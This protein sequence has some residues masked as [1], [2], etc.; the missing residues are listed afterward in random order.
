M[1]SQNHGV[2]V[3]IS[4]IHGLTKSMFLKPW[5]LQGIGTI[6]LTIWCVKQAGNLFYYALRH[7]FGFS[8]VSGLKFLAIILLK[9][10]FMEF[11]EQCNR[12]PLARVIYL[13][14]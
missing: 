5:V 12:M 9:Y 8:K 2:T 7:A 13:L 6:S 14:V 10:C 3:L 4:N 1:V 11:Q